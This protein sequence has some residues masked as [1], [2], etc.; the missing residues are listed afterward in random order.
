MNLLKPMLVFIL[1][2]YRFPALAQDC[3]FRENSKDEATGN[4]I[5]ISE[6]VILAEKTKNK[7]G[8][9]LGGFHFIFMQEGGKYSLTLGYKTSESM[10]YIDAANGDKIV[11]TLDNNDTLEL[12]AS[13]KVYSGMKEHY[14]SISFFSDFYLTKA[15]LEKL[16]SNKITNVRIVASANPVAF[17]IEEKNALDVRAMAGCMLLP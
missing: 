6:K 5:R 15:Q 9:R 3:P 10:I 14:M 7:R 16:K 2:L 11:L 4:V 1:T 17:S 13:D 12:P 8:N